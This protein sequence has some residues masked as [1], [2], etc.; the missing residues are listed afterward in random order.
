VQLIN[1]IIQFVITVITI[2]ISIFFSVSYWYLALFLFVIWIEA[3]FISYLIKV[4]NN[5]S[6]ELQKKSKTV[7]DML[8]KNRLND[9]SIADITVYPPQNNVI[10][11]GKKLKIEILINSDIDIG[12]EF[13]LQFISDYRVKLSIP[14]NNSISMNQISGKYWFVIR[15]QYGSTSLKK[16]KKFTIFVIP[17]EKDE[18][19]FEIMGQDSNINVKRKFCLHN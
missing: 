3:A 15:S 4:N 9:T 17:L 14:E 16:F 1:A 10:E 2:I 8:L 18:I 7:S 5:I 13:D 19:N 6:T 11:I 12:S